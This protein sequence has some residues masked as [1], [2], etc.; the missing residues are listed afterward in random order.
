MQK[1]VSS[2]NTS[3]LAWPPCNLDKIDDKYK[4]PKCRQIMVNVHQADDCGCRYCLE[5]LEE[6]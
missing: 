1:A 3:L 6:M 4:C 2:N 5:C